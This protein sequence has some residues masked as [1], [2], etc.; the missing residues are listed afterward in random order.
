MLT[1]SVQQSEEMIVKQI[2]N[3]LNRDWLKN[4]I[5]LLTAL[6]AEI[7]GHFQTKLVREDFQQAFNQEKQKITSIVQFQ[8]KLKNDLINCQKYCSKFEL[9]FA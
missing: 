6:S 8:K 2:F 3:S 7:I 1:Q 9:N 4:W 5:E